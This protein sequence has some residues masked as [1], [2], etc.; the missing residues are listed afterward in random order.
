MIL[1]LLSIGIVS[2]EGEEDRIVKTLQSLTSYISPVDY[3]D[4]MIVVVYNGGSSALLLQRVR[5]NFENELESGLIHVIHPTDSFLHKVD[6]QPLGWRQKEFTEDFKQKA[7]QFNKRLVFLA[8]YCF[9]ISDNFLMVSDEASPVRAFLPIIKQ[10]I[11]KFHENNVSLYAHGFGQF[12]FP[13]LGLLFSREMTGELAEFGAM[14]PSGH[15]ARS[16]VDRY[17]GTRVSALKT[18]RKEEDFVFSL[19]KEL[20]GIKPDVEFKSTFRIAGSHDLKNAFQSVDRFA[21]LVGPLKGEHFVMMF[22][23]PLHI[24]RILI[25]TGSPLYGDLLENGAL[26]ACNADGNSSCDESQC[27]KVAE[28]QDPILDATK[29][30]EV[31]N[32]PVKCLRLVVT[33]DHKMWV[34]IRSISLWE[35]EQK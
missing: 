18:K 5:E 16:L 9:R 32:S 13:A 24:N 6:K 14:F 12:E 26:W 7:T 4:V 23:E 25:E 29:L 31:L 28:F 30:D 15:V 3:S 35:N 21:W 10:E 11:A 17:R 8:E 19:R 22:K 33:A 34:I 27:T 1:V 2:T 20:R